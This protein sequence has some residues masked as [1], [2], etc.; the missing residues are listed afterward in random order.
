VKNTSPFHPLI[1]HPL[2]SM[3]VFFAIFLAQ[4]LISPYCR[5]RL[6]YAV[7]IAAAASFSGMGVLLAWTYR[8]W[9]LYV[10]VVLI[11]VLLI[12]WME[13]IFLSWDDERKIFQKLLWCLSIVLPLWGW[14]VHVQMVV[15]KWRA[16][17]GGRQ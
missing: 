8:R 9:F 7:G 1:R 5:Y 3:L 11:V 10:T 17:R 16:K 6:E 12:G 13:M 4:L 14:M 2:W 15:N